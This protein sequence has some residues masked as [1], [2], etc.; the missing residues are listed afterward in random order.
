M[1]VTQSF[2]AW[3]QRRREALGLTRNEL[4]QA[5][6][7]AEATVR[8]V[9]TAGHLPSPQTLTRLTSLLTEP[10]ARPMACAPDER[11]QNLP[12]QLTSFV[13]RKREL[14]DVIATLCRPD[15]R[16]VTLTGPGGS[17]KSRLALQAAEALLETFA[18]GC[19]FVDLAP[20]TAPQQ[21][22]GAIAQALKLHAPS[23]QLVADSVIA[24]LRPKQLLLLLDNYEH[25]LAAAD[26]VGD[27]LRAAPRVTILVTSRVALQLYGEYEVPLA[28]L[29]LP[30]VHAA[31][32]DIRAS[33]A[34]RLFVSRA[35]GMRLGS[36]LSELDT[37]A[38][39]A[40]CRYLDGLPLAIELAAAQVKRFA[41]PVLLERIKTQG[42]L[43]AL[44]SGPRN[45]PPRQQTIRAAIAWSF[46]LLSAA[47]QSLFACLGVFAGRFD[48]DAAMAVCGADPG[49][50]AVA[51]IPATIE[52]LVSQSLVQAV[53]GTAVSFVLLETIREYALERLRERG[54]EQDLR[55]RHLGYYA[56]LAEVA[57]PQLR[58][59]ARHLWLERLDAA[60]PDIQAALAWGLAG[61]GDRVAAVRLVGALWYYWRA[62]GLF[63]DAAHWCDSPALYDSTI[64]ALTR[65]CALVG[66]AWVAERQGTY[67]RMFMLA[68]A[69]LVLAQQID[70]RPT[71]LRALLLTAL[72]DC[73]P[74][75][76]DSLRR[77]CR[78]LMGTLD[79]QWLRC[80][81]LRW[82]G[83]PLADAA[84]PEWQ[85]YWHVREQLAAASG[86]PWL[87]SDL[88]EDR[89]AHAQATHDLAAMRRAVGAHAALAREM[90]SRQAI[91]LT[92]EGRARLALAERRWGEALAHQKERLRAERDLGNRNGVGWADLEIALLHL[93]SGDFAA[94]MAS[95]DDAL[96]NLR[97]IEEQSG[98]SRGLCLRSLVHLWRG[99]LAAAEA[100][101]A[102]SLVISRTLSRLVDCAEATSL[103]HW[104]LGLT[105]LAQGQIERADACFAAAAAQMRQYDEDIA[106]RLDAEVGLDLVASLRGKHTDAAARMAALISHCRNS[107]SPMSLVLGLWCQAPVLLATGAIEAAEACC[108]EALT[109]TRQVGDC[110]WSLRL[111]ELRATIAALRE[112]HDRAARWWGA[113]ADLRERIGAPLW[114]LDRPEYEARVAATRAALGTQ[115]FAA[116]FAAGHSIGWEHLVDERADLPSRA[117]MAAAP[118]T[119]AKELARELA[120]AAAIQAGLLPATLPEPRGWGL[121]ARLVP[122]HETAGDFYDC[123]VLSDGRVGLVIADVAGKGLGP[124]LYMAT[125][126]AL[127]RT[128]VG[129]GHVDPADVLARVNTYL[130]KETHADLFITAFYGVLDPAHGTLVYAN[131]GHPPPLVVSAHDPARMPGLAPTGLVLGVERDAIWKQQ[132][133]QLIPGDVVLLYTDGVTEAQDSSDGF[134]ETERLV[135][136]LRAS[137]G[138]G[139][140]AAVAGVLA[141]V[142]A[143]AG[144]APQSDDITLLAAAWASAGDGA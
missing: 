96:E 108:V 44:A 128:L 121:A 75:K 117:S 111:L 52:R 3:V 45:V 38:I 85:R 60:Y 110:P 43:S 1:A 70:D 127:I 16:L 59:G 14:A 15:V 18:D 20:L 6:C 113:V 143:F 31:P 95:L 109:L 98:A 66:L 67:S 9:E 54:A 142:R 112:Q 10:N 23:E 123:I 33:D 78:E 46:D 61:Q 51:D 87:M 27:I 92:Y 86:D 89:F 68:R 102:A 81:A 65:A 41:P 119:D 131:A 77:A 114:P 55:D 79:D 125:G 73:G 22:V 93:Q 120:A 30:D 40:I 13:G 132:S 136:A 116:E 26:L 122:A 53:P 106:H 90:R 126:R 115:A 135:A 101:G 139:A 130:L 105:A 99:D 34:V 11:L 5:I 141:A 32:E 35:D 47:E 28:P 118:A 21:V 107:Y 62:R 17:G 84:P 144:T 104:C 12:A 24:F 134:F 56:G 138:G 72:E 83:R 2:G 36:E 76:A 57:E 91:A 82:F 25:L 50:A 69:A 39:G 140:E 133:I 48:A 37:A 49:G 88:I 74:P 124:A 4:A 8:Q 71:M 129:D 63:G 94:A 103:A 7:C 29:G 42:A 58:S 80:Q 97:A 137:L 100:D 64:P 19:C